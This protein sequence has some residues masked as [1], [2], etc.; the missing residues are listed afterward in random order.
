[1]VETAER[2]R[3]LEGAPR[4][5]MESPTAFFDRLDGSAVRN[6]YYGELYLA[7]H[8]GTYTAQ[9]RIKRGV[10]L[11]EYALREAEFLAGLL[12][13]TGRWE[14]GSGEEAV[15]EKL[16]Q[17]WELLLL[18]EFHDILPGSS[19]ER[20][21]REAEEALEQVERESREL[22]QKL[23][24]RLAAGRVLFNS[25]SWER[26]FCG[27]KLPPCGYV[28]LGQDGEGVSGGQDLEIGRAHV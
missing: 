27:V 4:C 10:R 1:M 16:E 18:Q 11:A 17:L 13:L 3:D 2:C 26:A 19:I 20:V 25:L 8:R 12:R 5:T 21:N 14:D 24:C 7:W 23:S 15:L 28:R 9:A 22:A 6:V